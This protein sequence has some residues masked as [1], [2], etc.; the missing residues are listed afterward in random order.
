[1]PTTPVRPIPASTSY[2][3]ASSFDATRTTS[4]QHQITELVKES[5]TDQDVQ[6]ALMSPN[7]PDFILGPELD[8]EVISPGHSFV[9]KYGTSKGKYLALCFWPSKV[10]GTPHAVMGMFKLFHL[11]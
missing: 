3:S 6:D 4:V 7:P 9:W 2:P 10:D 5:T 11:T 8:T 1:M